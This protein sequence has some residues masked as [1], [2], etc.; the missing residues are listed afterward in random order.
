MKM[1]RFQ[2][3]TDSQLVPARLPDS[4]VLGASL[5]ASGA[6]TILLQWRVHPAVAVSSSDLVIDVLEV[7]ANLEA[8]Q[9]SPGRVHLGQGKVDVQFDDAAPGIE[10]IERIVSIDDGI[11]TESN[12]HWSCPRVVLTRSLR[13]LVES[14]ALHAV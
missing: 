4:E 2:V 12:A 14:L 8:G 7:I 11:R 10:L 5:G 1:V 13:A 9:S 6:A 3:L